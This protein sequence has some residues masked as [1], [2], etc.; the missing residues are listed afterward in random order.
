MSWPAT[1][2]ASYSYPIIQSY[3][4]VAV[5]NFIPTLVRLSVTSHVPQYPD[6]PLLELLLFFL[7]LLSSIP[8]LSSLSVT[9]TQNQ[10]T[11]S[12]NT[13][14]KKTLFFSASPPQPEGV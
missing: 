4:L 5:Q 12:T 1:C 2:P 6:C 13:N 7:E 14:V 8:P 10:L 9:Q 3:G 11:I